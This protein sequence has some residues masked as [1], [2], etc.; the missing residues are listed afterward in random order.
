M[1]TV[2]RTT[3]VRSALRSGTSGGDGI[4]TVRSDFTSATPGRPVLE[5]MEP[6][7][8]LSAASPAEAPQIDLCLGD[9][10]AAPMGIPSYG[11]SDGL[12]GEASPV[13]CDSASTGPASS[14][15]SPDAQPVSVQAS[16]AYPTSYEQYLLELINR[17]RANPG[18]EAAAFHIDLNEGSPDPPITDTPKQPLAFNTHL[19]S[20]ARGHTQWMLATS[21]LSHQE[22]DGSWPW[23]RATAAG[24]TWS[25]IGENIAW[26]GTTGSITNV[27]T[28][29]D[30]IHRNL[31]VDVNID[32]RG[33]RVNMLE[34]DFKEVGIGV[35][36][37]PWVYQGTTYNSIVGTE[38]FG[39]GQ[40]GGAFLTGVVYNDHLTTVNQFYT[41]GEGLAGA[42]ITAQRWSDGATF[43][44]TTWAAGGYTLALAPGTYDV[45]ASG[46]GLA[47]ST[48]WSGVVIASN[49]VKRDFTTDMAAALSA[50]ITSPVSNYVRGIG[51]SVNMAATA[52]D[53]AGTV[54]TVEFFDGATKLGNGTFSGG[55]WTYAW[56]TTGATYGHHNVTARATDNGGRL[57]VSAPA[58][59][60]EIRLPGDGNGD[61]GVDGLDYNLWQNGYQQPGS[62]FATGDYNGDGG[63]DGLDYNTWQ[64]NYNKSATYLADDFG[65]IAAESAAPV[66]A[67]STALPAAPA[68]PEVAPVAALVSTPTPTAVLPTAAAPAD[69]VAAEVVAIGTRAVPAITVAPLVWVNSVDLTQTAGSA[70]ST[71]GVT[72]VAL[73]SDGGLNLLALSATVLLPVG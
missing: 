26:A 32:G 71:A 22:A 31:F 15:A 70:I 68:A 9:A 11:D 49:N 12:S 21:T 45:V 14:A 27:T 50:T 13:A 35:L 61:A 36:T 3:V 19:V 40:S 28:W 42:T 41:P 30:T 52:T 67:A 58:T 60:V 46:G 5:R 63:V 47:R 34:A 37:G 38:D 20:S 54:G 33:H 8:L 24:Y 16:D 53:T 17:A 55:V 18:A 57:A 69:L 44:T 72:E 4:L 73:E 64:N 59:V 51:S 29:V 7:L 10:T 23:D 48:G 6:R 62:T 66:G 56:N 39:L 1:L 25:Y 2:P 43:T 65:T